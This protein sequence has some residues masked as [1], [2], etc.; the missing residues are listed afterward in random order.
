MNKV[1]WPAW[2]L[3]G[4]CL[5]PEGLMDF[6][7][8]L[9]V[10]AVLQIVGSKISLDISLIGAPRLFSCRL[11]IKGLIIEEKILTQKVIDLRLKM[12]GIVP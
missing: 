9:E 4:L 2:L 5:Q 1:G 12:L 8:C 11:K 3:P 6:I 7:S 10:V